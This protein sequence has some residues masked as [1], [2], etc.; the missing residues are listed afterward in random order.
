VEVLLR[1]GARQLEEDAVEE[2]GLRAAMLTAIGRS[3]AQLGFYRDAEQQLEHA[4][5]A[6]REDPTAEPGA[7]ARTLSLLAHVVRH[8]DQD[9][10][11]A[12]FTPAL[13]LAEQE[14]GPDDPLVAEILVEFSLTLA[15]LRPGDPV[16]GGMRSRAVALLRAHPSDVRGLLAN[17]LTVWARGK[18]PEVAIPLMREAL[19]LRRAIHPERHS[20]VAASLSDLGLAMEAVEPLAADSLL[21]QAVEILHAI[22]G[23]HEVLLL[24]TMNNLAALRRDRGAFAAAEPLYREV[25]TLRRQLYPEQ[26]VQQAYT[27]YGLGVVLSETGRAVEGE[28]RLEEALAILE[29]ETPR[30]PLVAVTRAAIGHARTRQGDFAGAE[31]LLLPAWRAIRDS[32]LSPAEHPR[33]LRRL[34]ALYEA[35]GRPAAASSY[36]RQLDSVRVTL[37]EPADSTG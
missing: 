5:Q 6:H 12:L 36:R 26:Q 29:R 31:E 11:R 34:V 37:R 9:S 24:A 14:L 33:T 25:L 18:P 19:D 27:L 35:W 28:D 13:E 10:A 20:A 17:A 16:V 23:R 15:A 1:D 8:R 32:P 22:H 30:S 2:P 21:Q 7:E 4:I 3:F